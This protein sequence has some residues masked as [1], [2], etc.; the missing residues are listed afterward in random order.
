M[1][2]RCVGSVVQHLQDENVFLL[3]T[4]KL[5]DFHGVAHRPGADLAQ[6]LSTEAFKAGGLEG[7]FGLSAGCRDRALVGV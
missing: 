7:A 4:L 1:A 3:D 2:S 6:K 5:M